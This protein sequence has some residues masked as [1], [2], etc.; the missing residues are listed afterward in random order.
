MRMRAFPLRESRLR[1]PLAYAAGYGSSGYGSSGYGSL[2]P[3][4]SFTNGYN[5]GMIRYVLSLATFL[6]LT[7]AHAER[8]STLKKDLAAA[9]KTP[10]KP[11]SKRLIKRISRFA[12]HTTSLNR[13]RLL[14]AL[15]QSKVQLKQI[16]KATDFDKTIATKKKLVKPSLRDQLKG[17]SF[18]KAYT[19]KKY[20]AGKSVFGAELSFLQA[21]RC[22]FD[23]SD[24]HAAQ[25]T[26]ADFRNSSMTSVKLVRAVMNH[27][28]LRGAN[29]AKA[30]LRHASLFR[31]D[32]RSA[33][34]LG[35]NFRYAKLREADLRIVDVRGA[36]FRGADLLGAY[37]SSDN[38]LR[39]CG[40]RFDPGK[41]KVVKGRVKRAE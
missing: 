35:T 28:D 5:V 36:D 31:A 21:R 40:A 27:A 33:I 32:F 13:G 8:L 39:V 15:I 24:F 14:Q 38:W 4:T 25:L 23:G 30:R 18:G 6:L 37:V 1:T 16:I 7:P 22:K 11:V 20:Q 29:L 17:K 12:K 3:G 41:W 2:R 9:G 26:H 10:D 34:L 19:S